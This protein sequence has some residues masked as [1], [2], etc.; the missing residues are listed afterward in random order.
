M[1][2]LDMAQATGPL[3]EYAREMRDE[4]VIVTARGKAIAALVPV[5]DADLEEMS[6]SHNPKFLALIEHSRARHK[7]EGGISSATLRRRLKLTA[8][9]KRRP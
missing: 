1:K 6:L 2:T 4:P 3:G 9:T 5:D 7:A 8:R